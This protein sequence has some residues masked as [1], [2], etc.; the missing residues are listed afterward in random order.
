MK[1]REVITDD[2][3]VELVGCI[4][5]LKRQEIYFN[6]AFNVHTMCLHITV[7]HIYK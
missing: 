4:G 2:Y 7:L 3:Y 5:S 6:L 1:D